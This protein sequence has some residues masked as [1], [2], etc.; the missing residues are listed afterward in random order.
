MKTKKEKADVEVLKQ[1]VEDASEKEEKMYTSY[2]EAMD[3]RKA[4]EKDLR[5]EKQTQRKEERLSRP[6]FF[7]RIPTWVKYVGCSLSTAAAT[8]G[9]FAIATSDSGEDIELEV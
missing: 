3:T 1:A 6:G 5:G 9:I 7:E 8:L 2:K 4:A